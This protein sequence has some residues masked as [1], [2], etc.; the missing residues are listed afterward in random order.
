MLIGQLAAT[1]VL[2]FACGLLVRSFTSLVNVDRGF[3]HQRLLSVRLLP[4][5]G[6]HQNLKQQEYYPQLLQKFAALA[7]VESVGFARYVGSINAQLP[8]QPIA[9][10]SVLRSTLL[11]RWGTGLHMS[12][13]PLEFPSF[14][15]AMWHGR[16]CPT[17]QRSRCSAKASRAILM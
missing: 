15:V 12:F 2:V 9:L 1:V 4:A 17:P 11:A 3:D 10:V 5:P 7:G 14:A 13:R 8:P 6:G 16:I